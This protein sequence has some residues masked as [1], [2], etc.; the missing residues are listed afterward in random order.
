M[1][2][3][4]KERLVIAR[5]LMD[6]FALRTGLSGKGGDLNER[7]LWTDAFAVQTFFALAHVCTD[8]NY[9]VLALK[10]IDEVHQKLGKFHPDDTCKGWIS[11]LSEQ[12]GQNHP[13]AGG[14]R[15]GKKLAERKQDEPFNERLEWERDWQYFHYLTRWMQALLQTREETNEKQYAVWA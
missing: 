6:D 1:P 2:V 11:G 7:Y 9:K 13:T 15:I 14:L 12:Q 3:N 8:D 4:S 5:K 10:L